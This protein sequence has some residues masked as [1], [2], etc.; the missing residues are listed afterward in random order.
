MIK[1]KEKIEKILAG[2]DEEI[3]T[4]S[5]DHMLTDGIINSFELFELVSDLEDEFDMEIDAAYVVE[6]HFGNMEKIIK[7]VEMLLSA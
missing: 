6:E 4:Y 1:V 2:I 3:L 7:L 5:G